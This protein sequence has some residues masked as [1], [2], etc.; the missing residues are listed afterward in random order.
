[1]STAFSPTTPA[2]SIESQ[3]AVHLAR[4]IAEIQDEL[5]YRQSLDSPL[6]WLR[7]GTCTVDEQDRENSRKPF[8]DYAYFDCVVPEF[9]DAPPKGESYV[10]GGYKS[11]T[12]MMS[13]L[14]SGLAVH[15][16]A[17]RRDI[18]VIVQSKDE[19]RASDIIDKMKTL[20]EN[21]TAKLK[22]K[23]I[24]RGA[25][26][27]DPWA[28]AYNKLEF[29]NG[30]SAQAFASG[31]DNTR[32]EHATIYIF[33]EGT[34]E[35]ELLDCVANALA[36]KTPHIW[37]VASA[38]PSPFNEV[39]KECVQVPWERPAGVSLAR[40]TYKDRDRLTNGS[41]DI[42]SLTIPSHTPITQP[43]PGLSKHVSPQG[44]VILRIHYSCDPSMRDDAKLKRVSKVFGGI[45]SPRWKREMEI[46]AEAMGGALVHQ[47]YDETIHVIPDKDI[48]E[49]GCLYMSLDPHPRTEHAGL[50]LLVTRDYDFYVYRE[51]WPSNVY[52]TGKRLSDD[53]ACNQYTVRKYA[54]YIAFL[55]GNKIVV[56]NENEADQW[57]EYVEQAGGERIMSRY[58][59][60]AGKGFKI[61]G[62]GQPDEFIFD[63]YLEYG[64]YCQDPIKSHAV[65]NDAIDEL[66]EVRSHPVVGKWSRLH[67]AQSCL[68]IRM[69]FKNHRWA[70]SSNS[71]ARDLNQK[72]SQFRTHSLDNLRYLAT[73]N[74]YYAESLASPRH[75]IG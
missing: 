29:A 1:M 22:A 55:E 40:V 28:Q 61:S 36:A 3:R 2:T 20:Y 63:K 31:A 43:M 48:P 15:M 41:V 45:G 47:K 32:S 62:E 53:E 37:I 9:L 66:L 74:L 73:S 12:M 19:K 49:Y 16:M 57:A 4:Q 69:E 26:P 72:V 54:E 59:D 13:W 39:W 18:R 7:N 6:F 33:D 23:W 11:R 64:I 17:T 10:R 52:G 42:D 60:Q 34:L 5:I 24:L 70:P 68:E 50:W 14:V 51:M 67:I 65:G 56:H 75:I 21:S 71:P 38:M 58:M 46:D 8:P 25:R 35:L 27:D 30:S 44:W